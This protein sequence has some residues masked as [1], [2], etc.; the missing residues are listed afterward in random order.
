MGTRASSLHCMYNMGFYELSFHIIKSKISNLKLQVFPKL[1]KCGSHIIRTLL[2][3]K[4][5]LLCIP[6]AAAVAVVSAAS[7]G[8]SL[9]DFSYAL[10]KFVKFE[11]SLAE[12]CILPW[13]G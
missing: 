5:Q 6:A 13:R 1:N 4:G 2:G 11:T 9:L 10:H 8:S 12:A 3:E 7:A